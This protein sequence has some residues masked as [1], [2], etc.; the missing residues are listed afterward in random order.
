MM[1]ADTPIWMVNDAV[2]TPAVF[3]AVTV[4]TVFANVELMRPNTR[5]LAELNV[6]PVGTGG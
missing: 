5:P 1:G 4:N 6:T 3:C 2:L